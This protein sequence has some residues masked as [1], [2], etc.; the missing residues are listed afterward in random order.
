MERLNIIVNIQRAINYDSFT[1]LM[2]GDM[3]RTKLA[4]E[5]FK[6]SWEDLCSPVSSR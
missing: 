4:L 2:R 6:L 3:R 1:L 5:L